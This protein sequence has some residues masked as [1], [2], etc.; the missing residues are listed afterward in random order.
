VQAKLSKSAVRSGSHVIASLATIMPCAGWAS[1]T[2]FQLNHDRSWNTGS[3]AGA[4][5]RAALRADPVA[6]D[7]DGAAIAK[8][9]ALLRGDKC[10]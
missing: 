6:D 9:T 3:S 2:A 4:Y 8:K 10:D 5:H 1:T 7:D